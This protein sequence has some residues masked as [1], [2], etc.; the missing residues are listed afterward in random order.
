[1]AKVIMMDIK[2]LLALCDKMRKVMTRHYDSYFTDAPLTSTQ[3]TTVQYIALY[4]ETQDVFQKDLEEFLSIRGSSA[5]GMISYL[6]RDGYL[7]R[8]CASF[9]K[10][11]KRL[12]LTEKGRALQ[13]DLTAR[14]ERYTDSVFD[15]I[16]E[17]ELKVFE[18]VVLK[19]INNA[20]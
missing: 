17:E 9:D 8:E 3:A 1:M 19:I 2:N 7:S 5:S 18:S 16:S 14:R 12:V 11:Y 13:E 6:E 20:T 15:G 4:G 10:R